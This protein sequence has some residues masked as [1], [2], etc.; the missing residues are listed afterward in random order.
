MHAAG[1]AR[2]ALCR[3]LAGQMNTWMAD[4]HRC[5][6]TEH[7][8]RRISFGLLRLANIEPLIELAQAILAQGAPE[9]LHVHL[10]VYHSRHPLLVRSA[11]ERQLD[12]LLKRSDDDAA[13]L[14]A[15]PTLAKALQ[16]STERDHLFVVLASP[17]AE[18][19]RDHDYDWAI[20]EPSSMR[21]II[22]LAGRIRRHRS[23][24]SGEANLYLLSRNIRSLEGQNPAFQRPGFETPDFPLDS[25]DLHDLLDPALLARIDASP[26]IVEPFPLFPRSRLVD[27]EHRRL[28]ALMLADDPPASLLGVPLWWQTPA[29]LS[30]ALQTSQPFRAGAK[31]RCYALLPDEDDEERLHFSRYEEGTWSNQDNLLR[32][33]DLTYGPRIQTWGTVNY[34][35]ELVAMA[36]RE[37]LDLRQC[38]MRYGEVRLRENTQGWSYHPYLG[39]KKYN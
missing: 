4:L 3:A 13:A 39:F 11:I 29:S 36:G 9:G 25:H 38:A 21:S 22:Q 33:L 19:G 27:L 7:Q 18:V 23:G 10:C 20:V 14:F 30:G 16:A 2:P 35:E 1:E 17:V 24:F 28:R 6:H 5:H 37:D 32:N 26:R 31:E 8:G 15:R 34:R 12:E